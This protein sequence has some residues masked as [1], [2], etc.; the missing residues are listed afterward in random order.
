MPRDDDSLIDLE[1]L[2]ELLRAHEGPPKVRERGEQP[3]AEP[4]SRPSRHARWAGL[5][6]LLALILGSAL[7]F[8]I[9]ISLTPEDAAGTSL[10][11]LGFVPGRGWAVAQSGTIG[12]TGTAVA[13]AANRP[14]RPGKSI[15]EV[16]L[17]TLSGLS[18]RDILISVVFTTRG[19]PAADVRFPARSLPLDLSEARQV[20]ANGVAGYRLRAG[21]GGYNADVRIYFGAAPTVRLRAAA[22]Q[23][24]DRLVVASERVTITAL[25]VFVAHEFVTV[26]GSIDVRRDGETISVQGRD[27]GQRFFRNVAGASTDAT[28]AWT[29]MYQPWI[30][31]TLRAVW[32]DA[33]SP[34]ITIRARASVSLRM[35]RSGDFEV[36]VTGKTSLWRKQ[37]RIQQ[38]RQGT[39]RLLK[40]VRLTDTGAN[41]PTGR[42]GA[43]WARTSFRLSV[44]RGTSLRAA[45]PRSQAAPCYL[46]GVSAT[47]RA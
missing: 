37:V 31:T 32:G 8:G 34:P 40:T 23:Q 33:A 2:R 41:D 21:V 24:L 13:V 3:A 20:P 12:A 30:T 11:G 27:C 44:P 18:R 35:R 6:A 38:R 7:G 5:V 4:D 42:Q 14:L 45:F 36:A 29:T 19:D 25:P 1:E 22:Q 9:A 15:E 10:S 17:A 28:G 46:P 39:W 47:I 16:A 26:S 43:V